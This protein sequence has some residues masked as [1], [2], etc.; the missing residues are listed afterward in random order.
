MI[1]SRFSS[2][3]DK[4]IIVGSNSGVGTNLI[5]KLLSIGCII[6]GIDIQE[7]SNCNAHDNFSYFQSNP[8]QKIS[9]REIWHK[10]DAD[11]IDHLINLSGTIK[12]FK[13]I[14]TLTTEEWQE[15]FD[16]S[17]KSCLNSCQIFSSH[18]NPEGSIVNMSSG[19]AFAGQKNYGPYAA[20]K[21]SILSLTK[22]LATEL[23]PEIKVNAI[24][25]GAI[26][27]AFIRDT[28]NN[29]RFDLEKYKAITPQNRMATTTDITKVILFLMSD[30]SAHITGQC[31]HVNG[32]AMML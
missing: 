14:N 2:E 16:I 25:P 7:K 10:I 30:A 1:E 15:T 18:I 12:H 13:S 11:K 23:A 19:L 22:T 24:A 28:D 21:M 8:T 31:I 4:V 20:A 5:E 6:Y 9:L 27:T 32:G 3:K 29:M 17:F 26:D